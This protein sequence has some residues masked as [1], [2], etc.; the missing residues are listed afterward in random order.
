MAVAVLAMWRA[1]T[2]AGVTV[3]VAVQVTD[4]GAGMV[5]IRQAPGPSVLSS[6]VTLCSG[7][8]PLLVTV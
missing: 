6:T 2:S 3:W 5:A 8:S 7:T 4:P 1:V